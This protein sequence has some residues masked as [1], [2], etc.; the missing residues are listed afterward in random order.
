MWFTRPQPTQRQPHEDPVK[1]AQRET[2]TFTIWKC[3]VYGLLLSFNLLLIAFILKGM[4]GHFLW[5]WLGVPLTLAFAYLFT[6]F[7]FY[8]SSVIHELLDRPG[9]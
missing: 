2:W 5:R 8:G 7:L 1:W 3:R 4:P 9:N 6:A